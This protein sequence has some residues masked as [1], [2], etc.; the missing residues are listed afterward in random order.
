MAERD[1]TNDYDDWLREQERLSGQP[2]APTP[3]AAPAPVDRGWRWTQRTPDQTPR[4]GHY[5][6]WMGGWDDNGQ[7]WQEVPTG[8][9]D[10]PLD[11][12]VLTPTNNTTDTNDY[13]LNYWQGRGQD[14]NDIFDIRT[15]Q[16]K[17]GWRRTDR[18]YENDGFA[19]APPP[20]VPPVSGPGPSDRRREVFDE[21]GG[22]DASGFAWPK[23][24]APTFTAPAYTPGAAFQAPKPFSYDPFN[25]DAFNYDAFKAPAF[26]D[27]YKDGSY[28]GRRDE[29]MKAIENSSA[30]R[31]LTR[32]PATLKALAGWNQD[33][34][35]REYGNIVDREA[36]SYDR[37]RGNAFDNWSANRG[38]AFENWSANRG[39]AAD[40]Y[41]MNYGVSRDVWDRGEQQ[42][43]SAFDRNASGARDQ[44]DRNY[45]GAFDEFEFNAW[46][47]ASATFDDMYRRWKAELDANTSIATSGGD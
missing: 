12:S 13:G 27:I 15:G 4:D 28:Q 39:S 30:A 44:F 23:F 29:G 5:W 34:A 11:P 47:P 32:L 14:A 33:F 1:Y 19:Q 2:S 17:P 18:G 21:S 36:N 20:D 26:T 43:L 31:G 8:G 7:G 38:N 46:K 40:A 9:W 10:Q 42:Q 24:D 35:S 41:S 22:V 45:R 16:L 37:N 25:Y 6:R 3:S